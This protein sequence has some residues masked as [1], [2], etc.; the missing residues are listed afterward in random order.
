MIIV[1]SKFMFTTIPKQE[2]KVQTKIQMKVTL[3]Q[4][5]LS[6]D[7]SLFF[8]KAIDTEQRFPLMVLCV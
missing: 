8:F 2:V 1:S 3:D 4:G 7:N 6:Y 5:V